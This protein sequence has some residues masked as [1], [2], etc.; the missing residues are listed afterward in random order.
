MCIDEN[1]GKSIHL[2]HIAKAN[3]KQPTS[4]SRLEESGKWKMENGKY[5]DSLSVCGSAEAFDTF[6]LNEIN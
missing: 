5:G 1:T 6:E 2:G 4:T 3:V